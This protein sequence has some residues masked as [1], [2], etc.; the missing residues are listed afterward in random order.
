MSNLHFNIAY[1]IGTLSIQE[2]IITSTR[3]TVDVV[4]PDLLTNKMLLFM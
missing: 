1:K 3:R 4:L 2:E